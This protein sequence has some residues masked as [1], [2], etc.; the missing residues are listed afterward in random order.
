MTINEAV[1][2]WLSYEDSDRYDEEKSRKVIEA[3]ITIR[4]ALRR[5]YK[6]CKIDEDCIRREE[7]IDRMMRKNMPVGEGNT[8]ER[9]RYLQWLSDLETIK[10]LPS[11]FEEVEDDTGRD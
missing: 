10:E 4:E 7:A 1:N 8:K 2:T 11:V 9:F 5:G 3:R 6:L